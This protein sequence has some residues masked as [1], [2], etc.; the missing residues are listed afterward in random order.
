MCITIACYLGCDVINFEINQKPNNQNTQI[1]KNFRQK[2]KY[3][4]NQKSF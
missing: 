1:T 2:L 3:L 4:G